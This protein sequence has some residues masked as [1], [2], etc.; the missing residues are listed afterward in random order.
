MHDRRP[1]NLILA[2]WYRTG[3]ASEAS[4]PTTSGWRRDATVERI[5]YFFGFRDDARNSLLG[6]AVS[7]LA[8]DFEHLLEA[9]DQDLAFRRDTGGRRPFLRRIA[10]RAPSSAGPSGSVFRRIRCLWGFSRKRLSGV[11]AVATD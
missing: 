1:A 5:Y 3:G 7:G 6:L 9:I 2:G 4:R 8:K 11:F 10:R